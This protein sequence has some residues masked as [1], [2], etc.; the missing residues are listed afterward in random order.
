MTRLFLDA[1]V[2][3]LA[4]AVPATAGPHGGGKDRQAPAANHGAAPAGPARGSLADRTAVS[5]YQDT[6][7]AGLSVPDPPPR[8]FAQTAS[9]RRC[10]YSAR[11]FINR[12]IIA[13]PGQCNAS[14]RGSL[15]GIYEC[16]HRPPVTAPP[17]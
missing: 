8:P 7:R 4:I 6:E 5:P 14:R 11:Q 17:P 13:R 1:G 3:A 2:A 10:A 12:R 16:A 15:A 9:E